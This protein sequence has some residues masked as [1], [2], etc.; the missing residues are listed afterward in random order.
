MCVYL[1]VKGGRGLDYNIKILEKVPIY[2]TKI[3]TD[4]NMMSIKAYPFIW[5][6]SPFEINKIIFEFSEKRR[7]P[8]WLENGMIGHTVLQPSSAMHMEDERRDAPYSNPSSSYLSSTTSVVKKYVS[9]GSF[10]VLLFWVDGG[11]SH[12]LQPHAPTS[13][14]SATLPF[15]WCPPPL[16]ISCLHSSHG[17]TSSGVE[18]LYD[19][20]MNT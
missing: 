12:H 5:D 18:Y 9:V 16:L 20:I 1:G 3:V 6:V 14:V 4:W 2:G 8:L 19:V 11:G 7:W 17:K 10:L 15:P 13:L